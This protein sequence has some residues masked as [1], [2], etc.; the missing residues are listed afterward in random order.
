MM[1]TL[2]AGSGPG[3]GGDGASFRRRGGRRVPR[4]FALAAT[5]ALCLVLPSPPALAVDPARLAPLL[6]RMEAKHG[7]DPGGALR[8]VDPDAGHA[9]ARKAAHGVGEQGVDVDA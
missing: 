1:G 6:H 2:Q 5:V 7:M 3:V 9:V 4:S 8:R